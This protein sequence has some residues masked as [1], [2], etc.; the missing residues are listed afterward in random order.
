[1][2]DVDIPINRIVEKQIKAFVEFPSN[3]LL[4][5]GEEGVG[6]SKIARLIATKILNKKITYSG[7]KIEMIDFKEI[8]SSIAEIRRLRSNI[9]L[10]SSELVD[11]VYIFTNFDELSLPAYNSFLKTLEE[12]PAGICFIMCVSERSKIPITVLSRVKSV[13]VI[14]PSHKNLLDYFKNKYP[15]IESADIEKVYQLNSGLPVRID[16]DL[17]RFNSQD[18][19]IFN[20]AKAFLSADSTQKLLLINDLYKNR[21]DSIIFLKILHVMSDAAIKNNSSN[22]VWQKIFKSSLNAVNMIEENS[23]VRLVLLNF[24]NEII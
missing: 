8:K 11:K 7:P 5:F 24:V 13:N 17:I 22:K 10:K 15:N 21:S 1:M 19:K 2:Y 16:D 14:K 12:P 4:L 9:Y 23:Q 6:K 3:S 20:T 18:N